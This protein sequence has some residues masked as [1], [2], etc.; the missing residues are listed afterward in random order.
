MRD[1]RPISLRLDE[2]G[3]L[4]STTWSEDVRRSTDSQQILWDE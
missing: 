1:L 4:A 3:R 2:Y